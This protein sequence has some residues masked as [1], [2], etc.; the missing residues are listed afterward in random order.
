MSMSRL[1]RRAVVAAASAAL[2]VG[3]TLSLPHLA[4]AQSPDEPAAHT[5]P[6]L[7]AHGA[8]GAHDAHAAH[9]AEMASVA[10]AQGLDEAPAGSVCA[11]AYEFRT[12]RGLHCS[13]APML[14][15][16]FTGEQLAVVAP[17]P[18]T[19]VTCFGNGT[20]GKRFQLLYAR[21]SNVTSRY[22]ATAVA[23]RSWAAEINQTLERSARKTRGDR[24]AR[25]VTDGSCAP[26]VL[27]IT[28][29]STVTT[30]S[31]L[32]SALEAQHLTSKDR[33]YLVA[34]DDSDT[35]DS[36]CGLG[37]SM[38]D[39]SAGATNRNETQPLGAMFAAVQPSCW[40]ASVAAHE[41]MHTLGAVQ[42]DAPH[43]SGY[44]HCT[45]ESD[46][47]CYLDGPKTVLTHP[48]P[49]SQESLYDCNNDDYFSANPP[50]GNYLKTH[51][52]T[53]S[54]GWLDPTA[55][56]SPGYV[57][58]GSWAAFVSRQYI[59]LIGRPPTI[60]ESA[61][62]VTALQAGTTT[63]G[64]F[65]DSLRR[66]TENTANVD[67]V[68]RVYRAFLGRAPDVGG[69]R[70]W[71]KR[72]RNVAPAAPWTVTQIATDFTTSSE[73]VRKY[74]TLTNRQF[75]TQIYTDVLARKADASGVDYWT[76]KLDT[77]TKTKAQVMV[78]FS[79]SNEY[80]TK[81]AQNTDVAMAYVDL[82]GRMPTVYETDDW[83][84]RQQGGTT[85]AALLEELFGSSAYATHIAG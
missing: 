65:V 59:D 63:K 23:M 78:G 9:A 20:D 16:M 49:A 61:A 53:A 21:R 84:T 73:F 55:P 83:V 64:A 72:K 45:D 10:R 43:A 60:V 27:N 12:S 14:A 15:D 40:T 7:A 17:N 54:S 33:K 36:F 1:S 70:F 52:N 26:T 8:H 30:F 69:L 37:E 3:T 2:L 47:M 35:T 79:E 42:P 46:I 75:V 67:P 22:S 58:F 6:A 82:L 32:M 11:G 66:G 41:I 44:G 28:V 85:D 48:C 57:P 29:A 4:S 56:P 76:K 62:A 68:V 81:Q 51:W 71:I 31:D 34:W 38:P 18:Y 39:S 77:R 19:E 50:T 13:S 5:A 74:G 25:W 24:Q 80:K